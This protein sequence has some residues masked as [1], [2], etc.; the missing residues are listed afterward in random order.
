MTPPHATAE[1]WAGAAPTEADLHELTPPIREGDRGATSFSLPRGRWKIDIVV[2]HRGMQSVPGANVRVTLLRWI[3]PRT[4]GAARWNDPNTWFTTAVAW[5]PAVNEVLNSP[6]GR[7]ALA[8]DNGWRFVLGGSG[9]PHRMSLDGQTLDATRAGVATFDLD[10]T[11]FRKGRVVL[12]VA[13]IR[14]GTA[15]A[16]DNINLG[17]ASL[18][19]LA[20]NNPNVAVR[21]VRISP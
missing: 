16:A 11:P 15:A 18:E 10:V 21:S 6:D 3:D 8:V 13:I 4:T 2:H 7:S 17:P 1:P 12:L 20:L 9:Q 19:H 14:T 5:T